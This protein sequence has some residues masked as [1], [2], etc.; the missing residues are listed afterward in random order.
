MPATGSHMDRSS[1]CGSRTASPNPHLTAKIAAIWA[2]RADMGNN[3]NHET[4]T[5]LDSH[6]NM[7]VIGGHASVFG[8]LGKSADVR[9]FSNNCSKL[10]SVP[11]VDAVMAYD[12][13]YTMKTYILAVRNALQV[14][15]MEHNLIPP[16]I[17]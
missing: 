5:Q 17:L 14:P 6:A 8:H 16:F 7:V 3:D 2:T 1:T 9:P 12:C 15:S 13:L 10:E 4:S 11:I